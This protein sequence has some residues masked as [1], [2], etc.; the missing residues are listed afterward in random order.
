MAEI[1]T[2]SS[3][4]HIPLTV[5]EEAKRVMAT[6][7][8]PAV[9]PR[10]PDPGDIDGWRKLQQL[11]EDDGKAKSKPLLDRYPPRRSA[12]NSAGIPII[13]VRPMA[14]PMTEG[15]SSTRMAAPRHV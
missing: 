3:F 13:D 15:S 4:V 2:T 5:S 12:A 6:L 8:D 7:P 9:K 11:A 10:F 1:P 14:G